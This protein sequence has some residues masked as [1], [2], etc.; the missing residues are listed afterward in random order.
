MDLHKNLKRTWEAVIQ[1]TKYEFGATRIIFL[2]Q[3]CLQK[4]CVVKPLRCCFFQLQNI[5]CTSAE[6]LSLKKYE[7]V[8]QRLKNFCLL[9]AWGMHPLQMVPLCLGEPAF[10]QIRQNATEVQ[11]CT[12]LS[13][14]VTHPSWA[15]Q[16][17]LESRWW[18]KEIRGMRELKLHGLEEN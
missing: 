8:V 3:A 11:E 7:S 9:I 6:A 2:Y 4:A 18:W 12:C 1:T 17:M 10:F 15:S 5:R 13:G 16:E 14:A